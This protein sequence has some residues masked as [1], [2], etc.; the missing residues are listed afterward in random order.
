MN[1]PNIVYE[2]IPFES[3]SPGILY[4]IL[5]LR[6]AVFTTE[7]KCSL[8]DL[9]DLDKQALHAIG[10]HHGVICA[11][12]RILPPGTY[13]E[14]A[15]SFGRLA[16]EKSFR[17]KGIGMQLMQKV[18]HYIDIHYPGSPVNI[19][20]QLYLKAFYKRLGFQPLDEPFDE[21]GISHINM[22]KSK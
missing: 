16:V 18:M 22:I 11:T 12:V 2:I 17:K 5:A 21:G 10:Q 15:V 8:P 1:S 7:Q 3:L 14:N 6:E 9:D 19:S 4:D 20:A 13:K